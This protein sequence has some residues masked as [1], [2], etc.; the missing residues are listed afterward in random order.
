MKIS[1]I[2]VCFNS[3]ETIRDTIESIL[4][5]S[6][7]NIEYIIID[8]GSKDKTLEIVN[9]YADKIH[10]II[11]EPDEGIY[12]AM[13][14]GL[15][16]A[17]G[18][19]VGFLNSDDFY[20]DSSVV[21][22]IVDV[23]QDQA[24]AFDVCFSD[25]VYVSSDNKRIVRYWQSKPFTKGAFALGWCPA[26]PTFYV[27]KSIVDKYGY[28]DPSY[29]LAADAEFMMRYLE[30]EGLR[31]VYIPHIW[32]RMRVGGQTN[33]SLKNIVRQNKEILRALEMNGIPYSK[34]LFVT[35]KIASRIW[36]FIFGR[37]R[38]SQ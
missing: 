13:N 9:D 4:F 1:I 28:F 38:R 36:Q 33:Q 35:N 22:Q 27:R 6:Y 37:I 2:T 16:L 3:A 26:H 14:K 29:R 24:K 18:E 25:L 7:K 19:V 12:D 23:F 32:V 21:E 30:R 11:S 17:T 34:I 8:G 15:A 31:S 20:A 10:K 5:Q